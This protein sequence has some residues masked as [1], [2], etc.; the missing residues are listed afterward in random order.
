MTGF[1]SVDRVCHGYELGGVQLTEYQLHVLRGASANETAPQADGGVPRP[2]FNWKTRVLIPGIIVGG[3]LFVLGL[4][5]FQELSP[6]LSVQASPVLLKSVEGGMSGAVT[7][8]AAGW[9]EADPY[10]S[11]VTALT[12]GIV[13]EVLVLEGQAVSPGQVVARLVDEDARLTVK[14]AEDKVKELE[15]K[16][17]AERA[18]L[19]AAQTEWENPTER[20]R[21]I[22][23]GEAQL[24]E[25]KATLEQLSADIATEESQS[26][27]TKSQYD[28]SVGLRESGAISDQEFIRLRSQHHA[29]TSKIAALRMRLAAGRELVAK[30]EAELRASREHMAL[31]TEERRKLDHARAAASQAEAAL[32]QARTS[33]AEAALRFNRMEIRS[34]MKGVVMS[35]LTEPGSK[36]QVLSDNPGS[37]KVLSLYDP[38]RLQVRVD[39]RLADAAKISVGQQADIIVEVLP[40]QPFAGTVTRVLHEANIQKNTLEVK[41]ALSNPDPKLRPEMLARVKFLAKVEAGPD[42]ERHRLFVPEAAVRNSGGNATVWMLRDVEGDQGSAFSRPV[43]LGSTKIEGWIDV[44]EGLQAGDIVIANPPSELREGRKVRIATH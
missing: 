44:S 12:D 38:E 20:K 5:A 14:R 36:V 35:R 28:R 34:P 9:V 7:V 43:K 32:D 4:S 3:F 25:A 39:V 10:K 11:Y 6:A 37:A 2:P 13:Q 17:A 33:L 29:Q 18:E 42:E 24:A 21:A 40:D 1:A 15:A 16:L 19:L 41:V 31:R 8:Q 23:V 26:E 22:E 27:H 30:H